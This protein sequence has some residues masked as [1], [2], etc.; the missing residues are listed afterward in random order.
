MRLNWPYLHR[1]WFFI[2]PAVTALIANCFDAVRNILWLPILI[3]VT[4]CYFGIL[5]NESRAR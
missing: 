5:F 1:N 2:F 3:V 4:V